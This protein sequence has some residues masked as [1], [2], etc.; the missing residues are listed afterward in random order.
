MARARSIAF[1]SGSCLLFHQVPI[2]SP[3]NKRHI[4]LVLSVLEHGR[5]GAQYG[6]TE[7][8]SKLG[9]SNVFLLQNVSNP[10]HVT[11][12][13]CTLAYFCFYNLFRLALLLTAWSWWESVFLC[14]SYRMRNW[15]E[16]H[17]YYIGEVN[18]VYLKLILVNTYS[19]VGQMCR[20][21]IDD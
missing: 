6:R 8:S 3:A 4:C 15:K 16:T 10:K 9:V 2:R 18:Y 17:D 19:A 5:A 14:F 1:P 12:V 20:D 7:E 11:V 13:H 21:K